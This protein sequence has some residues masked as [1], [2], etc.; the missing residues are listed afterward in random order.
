MS[1]GQQQ[2]HG[3]DFASF[4]NEIYFA[5]MGGQ[6]PD[7]PMTF[8]ELEAR[9][10]EELDPEAFG[11][12]AGG[13]TSEDTVEENAEAFRRWRIVPRHL[14]D[15]SQRDLRVEI[16]GTTLPAPVVLA[17]IGVQGIVHDE[18]ELAVARAAADVGVPFCLSTVSSYTMEEVAEAAGD[19]RRWFQLYWP[20]ERELTDSLIQRAEDAGYEAIV[21][22]LDTRKLAWRPRDLAGAYLPFL[23]GQGI[24]NYTSDDVFEQGVPDMDDEQ[25]AKVLRWVQ[26][27][28]DESQTWED[29]DDLCRRTDLPIVVKGI[30]H[31]EDAERA[32]DAGVAGIGVSNHGGRQVDGSIAALDALP[33]VVEAVDGRAPIVFDSGIR[34][35]SDGMKAY[36]LGADVVMLGRPYVYGL[37]LAGQDGVAHV[38]R[39]FLADL[40]LAM[41]LSGFTQLDE[42]SPDVLVR[43]PHH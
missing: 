24:A 20:A 4:Q 25:Q 35:G 40:D 2:Q 17:P 34:T 1:E 41:A 8:P 16:F 5:G 23:H 22:T 32:L 14:R 6:T 11:Y 9:A 27:Y 12:V 15:V 21:V 29:L 28:S 37:G 33:D 3:T 43:R 18:A 30:L 31:P 39:S 13:A 7:L 10:K 19:T 38:V 26:V 42:L 36:A